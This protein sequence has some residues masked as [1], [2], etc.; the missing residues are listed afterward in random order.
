MLYS[1]DMIRAKIAGIKDVTRRPLK[2]QP[3]PD[4]IRITYKLCEVYSTPL[5]KDEGKLHW[6][7]VDKLNENRWLDGSQPYFRLP[8]APGDLLYARET[9]TR[10]DSIGRFM[11]PTDFEH[12]ENFRWRPS[13]HMPKEAARIWD[14]VVSVTVERLQDITE[15]DAI[16]EGVQLCNGNRHGVYGIDTGR[17]IYEYIG[18]TARESFRILWQSIYGTWDQ[19][20]WVVRIET[21]NISLTGKPE[22]L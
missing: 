4:G 22:N 2:V 9:W 13:I 18:A 14:E 5:K 10:I 16:R 8:C 21:K 20:P 17:G 3:L 19:N 12:P 7:G 15:E 11:Y 6:L 1:P